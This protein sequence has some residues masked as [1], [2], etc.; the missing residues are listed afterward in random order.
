MLKHRTL[1][2]KSII[3]PRLEAVIRSRLG[4]SPPPPEDQRWQAEGRDPSESRGARFHARYWRENHDARCVM[5]PDAEIA[6]RARR[7]RE[8]PVYPSP[9]ML[10]RA[11]IKRTL[12]RFRYDREFRG[13]RRVP[14]K[15]LADHVGLSREI[16]YQAMRG[17]ISDRTQ[18]VL[19]GVIIA[20]REGR[21]RFHRSG[22]HWSAEA[23]GALLCLGRPSL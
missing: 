19:S 22:Q 11:E 15:T 8:I 21:L 14:I 20:I 1:P 18:V 13:P 5:L 3:P 12:L 17:S 7:R 23:S 4:A 16:L 2:M 9:V 6:S 10:P